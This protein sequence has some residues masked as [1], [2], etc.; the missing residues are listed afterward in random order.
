MEEIRKSTEGHD[1][2]EEE[3]VRIRREVAE[4][5]RPHFVF[6]T[7]NGIRYL[8]RTEPDKAYTAIYD[9]AKY[10]QENLDKAVI[11]GEIPLEEELSYAKSYLN[12][13]QM[14]RRKL[15]V[16]WSVQD[17][18]GYVPCGCISEAVVTLLK[19]DPESA[20]QERTLSVEK[21][22]NEKKIK[23]FV[24]ETGMETEILVSG[25]DDKRSV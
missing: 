6:N 12:L 4:T 14:Q 20:R 8:I 7:M 21:V 19:K 25:E 17:A 1:L 24:A 2:S 15:N 10:M 9:L 5:L 3:V 13:E 22:A 18:D 11:G 23:I 16:K